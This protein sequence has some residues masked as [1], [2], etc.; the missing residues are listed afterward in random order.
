MYHFPTWLDAACDKAPPAAAAVA[1][2]ATG[3]HLVPSLLPAR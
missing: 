1:S 3:C 2:A